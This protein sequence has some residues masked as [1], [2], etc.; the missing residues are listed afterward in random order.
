MFDEA[1]Q[2]LNEAIRIRNDCIPAWT[3]RTDMDSRH[4]QHL[5]R[6]GRLTDREFAEARDRAEEA[7][8]SIMSNPTLLVG[9]SSL[10]TAYYNSLIN[11][12]LTN[13]EIYEQ[14][15]RY[16]E[17]ALKLNPRTVGAL[18]NLGALKSLRVAYLKAAHSASDEVFNEAVTSFEQALVIDPNNYQALSGLGGMYMKHYRELLD[19][20]ND[21]DWV[22]QKAE[23]KFERVIKTAPTSYSAPLNLAKLHVA[24]VEY[25]VKNEKPIPAD[26]LDAAQRVCEAMTTQNPNGAMD[27]DI[28]GEFL[29]YKCTLAFRGQGMDLQDL[30]RAMRIN[31]EITN[32]G[33]ALNGFKR[34]AKLSEMR[35][36]PAKALDYYGQGLKKCVLAHEQAELLA[37]RGKLEKK[38]GM[39]K[40][41]IQDLESAIEKDPSLERELRPFI[42][43]LK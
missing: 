20:G 32:M 30:D 26:K 23:E 21:Y 18:I 7:P 3:L 25:Y 4:L 13:D 6:C 41:A 43:E 38:L 39:K 15:I 27:K 24:R 17:R 2:Q 19:K 14:A 35:R 28:L 10:Y 5:M 34:L 31:E 8:P 37:E 22:F 36:D 1:L 42:Q 33:F 40:E 11:R 12:Q 9:F 16:C 29:F